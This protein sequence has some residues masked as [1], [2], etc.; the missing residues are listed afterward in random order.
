MI[1]IFFHFN[2]VLNPILPTLHSTSFCMI[3]LRIRCQGSK[4]IKESLGSFLGPS[5]FVTRSVVIFSNCVSSNTTGI[6]SERNGI[7]IKQ[8]VVK[9]SFSFWD[10]K[11]FNSLS[12]LPTVLVVDSD[13]SSSSLGGFKIQNIDNR[14]EITQIRKSKSLIR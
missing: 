6:L 11:S 5:Y 9:I 2:K 13:V 14:S 7:F 3:Y 10:R 1:S 4:K 8:H 12:N